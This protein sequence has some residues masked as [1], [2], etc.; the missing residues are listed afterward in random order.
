M[1]CDSVG[2]TKGRF[3]NRFGLFFSAIAGVL[4]FLG[5]GGSGNGGSGDVNGPGGNGGQ[6]QVTGGPGRIAYIS[7]IPGSGSFHLYLVDPDGQNLVSLNQDSDLGDYTG[8][9]WSSDGNRL[10]FVSN[11]D[12]NANFEIYVMELNGQTVQKVMDSERLEFSPSWSPDGQKFVYQTTRSAEKGW[13]IYSVNI[14]GTGELALAETE[15]DEG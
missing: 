15:L 7:Q 12:G 9:T 8:P 11:R 3:L 10:A 4:W 2:V 13:D 5:C 1:V 6:G 14:D